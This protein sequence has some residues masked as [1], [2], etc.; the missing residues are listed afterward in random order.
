[1]GFRTIVKKVIPTSV[2]RAIEPTGHLVESMIM[3]TKYGYPGRKLKIIG[4]TGTNGKTTT[5]FM[6]HTMLHSAGIKSALMTTVG[7]GVGDDIIHQKVHM[8]TTKS[9]ILQ[10]RLKSFADQGVE[11]VI[12]ETS[13]HALTQSRVWGVP[14]QIAVMTNITHDHLEYHGT[15]ERY[16]QAKTKLFKIAGKHGLRFG[17]ANAE[18]DNANAF[19]KYV[20]NKTTY[21]IKKGNLQAQDVDLR[22]D[23]SSYRAVIGNDSYD[24]DVK[25]PGEFNVS[26]SL[27]AISVGRKLGLT[28][29][30]IEKGIAAL[31][32]VEGRMNLID[33][34]QNFQVIVDFASTPDGYQK[35][36]ESMRPLVKG[37]LIAVFGSAGRRD[38]TKRAEQGAIAG[39][40][41]D[42]LVITEED[43]RDEDG[44]RIMQ[45]I[46]EGA[47]KQGKKENKTMFLVANREEAIGFAMTL[48]KNKD[49]AVV[50]LGKGHE[51]TIERADGEYPWNESE[52]AKAAIESLLNR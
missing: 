45:Q 15:F 47:R 22:A 43:D 27:A 5:S 11:W 46:A 31:E 50:L 30:Q 18:D 34:G 20:E 14:Y 24:I 2:F 10:Q 23:G 40:Y 6:I 49:D 33:A 48:A 37:N 28:K 39:K 7:Y 8:T 52:A 51:K 26:N 38:E 42:I 36:F 29:Q 16:L 12:V 13:S 1:M 32:T 44:A 21:G 3:T 25:I 41:A 35:F 9:S 19:L 17:V 4:V